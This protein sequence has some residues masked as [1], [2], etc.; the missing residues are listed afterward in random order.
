[1][2]I[3]IRADAVRPD[4]P[5]DGYGGA[6]YNESGSNATL[7]ADSFLANNATDNGGAIYIGSGTV[8]VRGLGSSTGAAS[9]FT[10]NTAQGDYGGAI[11]NEG[12]NL[13]VTYAAFSHNR[14]EDYGGA[15]E[16]DGGIGDVSGSKFSDNESEYGGALEVDTGPVNLTNDLFTGNSA[17]DGGAIAQ[18]GSVTTT[19][20]K[21]IV[22]GNHADGDGGG[23][24]ERRHDRAHQREPR[25]RQHARQLL[26]P[27][28]L[29]APGTWPRVAR[30]QAA[31]FG[32]RSVRNGYEEIDMKTVTSRRGRWAARACAAGA[33]V[34]AA[35]GPGRRGAGGDGP[36]DPRPGAVLGGRARRRDRQRA[37]QRHPGPAS[38]CTY[39]IPGSLPEVTSSLTIEGSGDTL[40]PANDDG[41]TA[42]K[43][44][45]AQ[46]TI[47]HLTFSDFY[48]GTDT[49]PGALIN[50][51]GTV[52]ITSSDFTGNTGG[53]NGGAILNED[54]AI[55]SIS[56]TTFLD[57]DAG[58]DDDTCSI[59]RHGARPAVR[60]AGC[61]DAGDGGAIANQGTSAATLISDSFTG[62]SATKDG[63]AV[64][65]GGG[66]VTVAA[67]APRP[68][69]PATS[70]ATPR[71][72]STAAPST[73]RPAA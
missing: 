23:I 41:F 51:G 22:T 5:D 73:T 20:S 47:S 49:T 50:D 26:Q 45:D 1:M 14:S 61:P 24:Y 27:L 63:G 28:L 32:Y 4:C 39:R 68:G 40:T 62:N 43:V 29:S 57:N 46:L 7:T 38:H 12:G 19:L 36:D 30:C 67:R 10:G 11:Y 60:P 8:T 6:I 52:T 53:Y 3:S 55:L 65:I 16:N 15:I 34:A 31:A 25:D 21:T 71:P 33:A 44:A 48:T 70:P 54:S 59:A 2:R 9:A 18:Y 37:R 17:Y 42:L 69:R 13:I 56:S 58:Y 35:G 66:T 64:Y 72:A